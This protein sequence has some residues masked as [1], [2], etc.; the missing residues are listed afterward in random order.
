MYYYFK[1]EWQGGACRAGNKK[2]S[3]CSDVEHHGNTAQ[4]LP[5]RQTCLL[6][7]SPCSKID[8][9]VG[10][11]LCSFK[12]PNILA[13]TMYTHFVPGLCC[14]MHTRGWATWSRDGTNE[15]QT[16]TQT[17][18][19]TIYVKAICRLRQTEENRFHRIPTLSQSHEKI[20]AKFD[21]LSG[22]CGG[23]VFS[24]KPGRVELKSHVSLT[25]IAGL[26]GP[27]M[28]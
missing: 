8:L 24:V 20:N 17:R 22:T 15:T 16:Q 10:H 19:K 7:T 11:T 5:S 21:V 6:T 1:N 2:R 18:C 9:N 27:P 25:A 3:S 26:T 14:L 28:L 4:Q 13:N 12:V 23:N